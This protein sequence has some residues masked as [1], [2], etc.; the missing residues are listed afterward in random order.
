MFSNL[1]DPPEYQYLANVPD[2]VDKF[3]KIGG[4]LVIGL[5]NF[6]AGDDTGEGGRRL[7]HELGLL[8]LDRVRDRL[9]TLA[10]LEEIYNEAL[11]CQYRNKLPTT[12]PKGKCRPVVSFSSMDGSIESYNMMR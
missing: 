12:N 1:P 10:R 4:S 7:S 5:D 2:A 9:A 8:E 3:R 6:T 11:Q